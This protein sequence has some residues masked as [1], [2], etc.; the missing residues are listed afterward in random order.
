MIKTDRKSTWRVFG[1]VLGAD[2]G[3]KSVYLVL[4]DSRR[5]MT[6]EEADE[7][8]D[9]LREQATQVRAYNAEL[10]GKATAC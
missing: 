3:R 6:P 8:A 1:S 5:S 9:A 4:V 7:L 2:P 10:E